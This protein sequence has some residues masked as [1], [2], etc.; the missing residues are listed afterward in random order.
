ME[1]DSNHLN[2]VELTVC[3]HRFLGITKRGVCFVLLLFL[4]IICEHGERI[5]GVTNM[6]KS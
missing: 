6:N 2:C 3:G 5:A 4:Y 1:S